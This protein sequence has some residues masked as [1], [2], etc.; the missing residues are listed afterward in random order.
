M[1]INNMPVFKILALITCCLLYIGAHAQ[2]DRQ[3][4]GSFEK[5]TQTTLHEKLFVH[6]DKNTYLA[7]ELVWF[8]IYNVNAATHKPADLSKVVYV[9]IIDKAKNTVL[10]AKIA[11]TDGSGAGSLYIPVNIANDNYKLRAYTNWM[12]NFGPDYY[13]EKQLTIINPLIAPAKAAN[14]GMPAFDI[15][16]FPEGGSL[17]NGFANRVAFKVTSNNGLGAELFTGAVVNQHNDTVARFKSLKAGIGSFIFTPATSSTYKAIVKIAG[18]S[19]FEDLPAANTNGYTMRLTENA[20]G[21][22]EITVHGEGNDANLY[23]FAH[24]RQVPKVMLNAAFANRSASFTIDP[25]KLGEGV[26]H[27]TIFNQARQP[28]CERLY[29]K[30]PTQK[31]TIE[32]ASD[33]QQ[34]ASRKK[35]NI[36]ISAKN[37]EGELSVADLSVSV[38]RTDSLQTIDKDD[39]LSYL[40]L[41]SDLRGNIETPGYYL[42]NKT[43]EARMALDNLLLSQ[44]W[45]KFNWSNILQDKPAALS[46]LPEYNGHLVT[47]KITNPGANHLDNTVAYLGIPGKVVQLYTAKSDSTG[48]LLFNTKNFFGPGEMVVQTNSRVD[49]VSHIEI[50]DPFSQNY[51]PWD[52]PKLTLTSSL[53]RSIEEHSL[54]TQS[55]NIY[56]ASQLKHFYASP[57]DSTAFYGKPDKT[58]KLDDY[59][60]FATLEEVFREYIPEADITKRGKDFYLAM[61]T[62]KTGYLEGEPLVL[63]DGVPVF[64]TTKLIAVDPLKINKLESVRSRYYWQAAAIDGIINLTTYKGDLGGVEMDANAV[65]I[66][67]EGMQLQ[68][69]FYSPAYDTN[70]QLKSRQPDFRNLLF[71][72]PSVITGTQASSKLSFYTS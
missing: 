53:R 60:R 57:G 13:F 39:I 19:Y 47:A 71:W 58:Y 51:T 36:D 32:A 45:R 66:D 8:K 70:A 64:N 65:I 56:A 16:F 31:L 4:Q 37:T 61:I 44:G 27:I 54:A 2:V 52:L 72:S 5:Y 35:I 17:V 30:Y 14:D 38:Y 62:T 18:K 23:L 7:G 48:R 68:R 25:A 46:F 24:T 49:S 40:W 41:R 55:L 12:K 29:F 22:L 20:A 50:A 67:Y 69:E 10:Q 59:T 6:T 28:V 34:Y 43:P 33:Q 26:S 42:D 9:E 21:Q 3:M 15:Q 63:L 11:M 1:K